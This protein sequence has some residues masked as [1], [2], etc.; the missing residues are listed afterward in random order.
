MRLRSHVGIFVVLVVAAFAAAALWWRAVFPF[1]DR[2]IA[3]ME[4]GTIAYLHVNLGPRTRT[5]VL[6]HL[7]RLARADAA[8]APALTAIRPAVAAFCAREIAVAVSWVT[9]ESRYVI[10]VIADPCLAPMPPIPEIVVN[11]VRVVVRLPF[12]QSM[13]TTDLRTADA[14][15]RPMRRQPV[16]L[17]IRPSV[18][19][20]RAADEYFVAGG[21][22]QRNGFWLRSDARYRV[23]GPERI[24]L[25]LK[26]QQ[27]DLQGFHVTPD[28]LRTLPVFQRLFT[29]GSA[30]PQFDVALRDG[31]LGIRVPGAMDD[32][33]RAFLRTSISAVS[34]MPQRRILD[35]IP[36]AVLVSDPDAWEVVATGE[37]TWSARLRENTQMEAARFMERDHAVIGASDSAMLRALLNEHPARPWY[38]TRTCGIAEHPNLLMRWE[39]PQR[40]GA[41]LSMSLST[42]GLWS[43]C[44]NYGN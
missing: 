22:M 39:M 15:L 2:L 42:G 5:H 21:A 18:L 40:I 3:G 4:D 29:P 11:G 32:Q 20:G 6:R 16:Q 7:D 36:A 35:Q 10:T 8:L 43:F 34:P 38:L 41:Y 30:V 13:S 17:L 24:S 23:G 28:L 33:L 9:P 1:P 19:T 25:L 26:P 27:G 14:R 44:G 31:V 12:P 37:R